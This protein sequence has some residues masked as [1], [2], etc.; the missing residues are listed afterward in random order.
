MRTCSLVI[1]DRNDDYKSKD[2]YIYT[3]NSYIDAYDEI[4][5]VDYNTE[6]R[7]FLHEIIDE[8]P[9]TGKIKNV[10]VTPDD[11]KKICG[12]DM[13]GIGVL[14]SVAFNIGI[15]RSTSDFVVVASTDI[16]GPTKDAL[17]EFLA[18]CEDDVFYTVSR[19]EL[20]KDVLDKYAPEDWKLALETISEESEPRVYYGRCT[21][22]D[23][24]SIINCCGDFQL[25]SRNIWTT[26]SGYEENMLHRNF[27][28]T[29]VQK[30]AVMNRFKIEAE[31]DLPVLHIS[32][33]YGD[34][35]VHVCKNNDP[36]YWV[37]NF[38][39]TENKENWGRPDIDFEVEVI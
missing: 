34:L 10:I 39:R 2:R 12:E 7:P 3:F 15:R 14:S 23:W 5:F 21:P 4:V 29:N 26:I 8:I 1:A 36:M 30:K 28:D 24:F 9:H 37:E 35:G 31:F 19:R 27:A 18:K 17:A 16:F 13:Q 38:K 32:H 20:E 33:D 6:G 11:A 25:A 22:N